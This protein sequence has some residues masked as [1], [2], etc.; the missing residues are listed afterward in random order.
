MLYCNFD[1]CINVNQ[2]H[3]A[4]RAGCGLKWVGEM[5][6]LFQKEKGWGE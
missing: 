4:V 3:V 6:L 1:P 2:G 5:G